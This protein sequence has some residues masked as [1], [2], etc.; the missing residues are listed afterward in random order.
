MQSDIVRCCKGEKYTNFLVSLC[1][2][3]VSI[4]YPSVQRYFTVTNSMSVVKKLGDGSCVGNAHGL[5][6]FFSKNQVEGTFTKNG[7]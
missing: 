6:C 3:V 2:S 4:L 1:S 5:F 7:T